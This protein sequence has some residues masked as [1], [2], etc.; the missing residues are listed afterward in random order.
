LRAAQI[1]LHRA[2]QEPWGKGV[3]LVALT[4]WGQEEHRR[5]TKDAGF[6]F[7]ITKPADVATLEAVL[8]EE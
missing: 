2:C 4:G 3:V 7:H 8:T 5:R 1:A 6:D